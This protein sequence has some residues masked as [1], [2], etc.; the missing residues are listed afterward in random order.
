M[1]AFVNGLRFYTLTRTLPTGLQID[2]SPRYLQ[3]N[4]GWSIKWYCRLEGH[5]TFCIVYDLH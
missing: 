5:I 4:A 2:Q 1:A 3:P